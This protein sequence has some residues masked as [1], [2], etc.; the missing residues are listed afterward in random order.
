M[1]IRFE[2]IEERSHKSN[3]RRHRLGLRPII[4]ALGYLKSDLRSLWWVLI[5]ND[6]NLRT[7]KL[8]QGTLKPLLWSDELLL[9]SHKCDL[10]SNNRAY[11]TINLVYDIIDLSV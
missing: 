7:L 8:L 4:L 2:K 1:G 11:E 5:S 10:S 6:W 3:L 9:W